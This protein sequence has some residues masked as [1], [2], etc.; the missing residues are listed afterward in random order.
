MNTT[1]KHNGAGRWQTKRIE[2]SCRL[3][4]TPP[5]LSSSGE[6]EVIRVR[7]RYMKSQ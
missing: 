3:F 7:K 2:N 5:A 4:G 6:I 1:R